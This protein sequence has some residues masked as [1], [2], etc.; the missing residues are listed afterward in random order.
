M[1]KIKNLASLILILTVL[2]SCSNDD[3][4]LSPTIVDVWS[5]EKVGY[6][7]ASNDVTT[8]YDWS[9]DCS[10]KT[11]HMV[12]TSTEN[13]T[14]NYY[15][16]ACENT[17]FAQE[18]GAYSFDESNNRLTISGGTDWDGNYNVISLTE[19]ELLLKIIVGVSE[20]RINDRL[21]EN[22]YY[23]FSRRN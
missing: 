12:L 4:N 2:I 5:I 6:M 10:T 23:K 17:F 14:F 21:G 20:N 8:E 22:N 7:N 19:T 9:H 1:K 3:D 11:D 16:A 13:F 15:S 18:I